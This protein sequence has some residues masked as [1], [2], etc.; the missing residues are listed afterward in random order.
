MWGGEDKDTLNLTPKKAIPP[1]GHCHGNQTGTP[2][3][4]A[5]TDSLLNTLRP[6]GPLI[7]PNVAWGCYWAPPPTPSRLAT[8]GAPPWAAAFFKK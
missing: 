2:K 1:R 6:Q 7:L 4:R 3:G 8:L 5:A